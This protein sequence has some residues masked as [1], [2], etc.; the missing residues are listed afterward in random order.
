MKPFSTFTPHHQRTFWVVLSIL[1]QIG[2]VLGVLHFFNQYFVFFYW[3]C[4]VV[5]VLVALFIS[6]RRNKLAY[7]VAWIVPILL[8]P[9]V[10]GLMYI[11]LG[12]G[13]KP[14]FRRREAIHVCRQQLIPTLDNLD[15]LRY[16]PDAAQQAWYL[17]NSALCPACGNTETRYFP[18]GEAFFPH[19]LEELRKARRYIFLE[20]F[21]IAEGSMWDEIL[22]I[23]KE[24][25]REGVEVRVIYDGIGSA[26][27]LD[28]DYDETLEAM[29]IHCRPFHPFLPILSIHQN[30]RDH[31]KLCVIDGVTG[32]VSGLNIADE[33][34]A[35]KERF[36]YWKDNA[37]LLRGEAVWSLVVFFLTMWDDG[38]K[39]RSD[40][41]RFRPQVLPPM[42]NTRGL[43]I[44]YVDTPFSEDTVC[45]DLHLLMITKARNYLYLTTPY[46]I[47]DETL[48]SA[49]RT[50]ARS[51]VDVRI[52][53]PHIPDK[54]AVFAVTQSN[55][56]S[57]LEAGIRIYEFTP[58]FLHSKTVVVD[59]LYASVGSCN[60][61]YRSFCLQFENGVWLCGT[62]SVEAVRDDF[63]ETI[64]LCE[65]IF[66]EDATPK[67][68]WARLKR[69]LLRLFSPLF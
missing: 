27:T 9:V 36:G 10:G 16:G 62:D 33:Y 20:Y 41:D 8:V 28:S 44:P 67:N 53:T 30:N 34:I 25:V 11:F 13:R 39:E 59:D 47:L 48:T 19:F 54:K 29:G 56:A 35:R 68:L 45:E 18:T 58:G 26:N 66:L 1:L 14:Q 49:L 61:D 24:K 57:L 3:V 4:V 63:L 50:A 6:T 15:F 46:L 5:S 64:P 21:I 38:R 31:R 60:L 7:K 43:V 40:H 69:S 32:F 51:G 12:G 42:E 2:L 17:Q 52:M 55:Y 65:E 22:D 37:L 23:L